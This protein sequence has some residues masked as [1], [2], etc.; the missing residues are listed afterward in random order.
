[1]NQKLSPEK[2]S[3]TRTVST[4]ALRML[5]SQ[6][7]LNPTAFVNTVIQESINSL[8]SD[9]L[10]ETGRENVRVRV[11]ID[12]VLYELGRV[13]LDTFKRISGRIKV[14]SKLDPTERRRIQ[15]GQF[16]TTHEG[17]MIN[18]RVEIAQT[19]YG[20]L[21]VI[22]IHEKKT[23]VVALSKL[24]LSKT[25]YEIYQNML[26][27]RSGLILFCGPTGSGKT[28]TLYSTITKLNEDQN[29]N[30]MTIEDP[31]EFQLEGINQMQTQEETGFT[32]ATGL[33]TILRLSP[34]IIFVG[35]IRDQE[36]AKIAVEL[37]LTGQLVLST[38]HAEDAVGALFRLLDLDIESYLLNSVLVGVVAQRLV[39]R[40]C[41]ACRSLYEPSQD[42]ADLFSK[43]MGSP[44]KHLVVGKG[45]TECQGLAYKGRV[46]IFE[47]LK[48][49]AKIRGLIRR[50]VDESTLRGVLEKEAFVTLFRDGLMKCEQG[51][52]TL[53][54]VLRSS[55]I[56]E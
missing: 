19:I 17:R 37:G 45:C 34:D 3:Q 56:I 2:A 6:T 43:V 28:T 13:D 14:L 31:V 36:T 29:F 39:R 20:E 27:R 22:R 9:I 40:V 15:E 11:R 42:E 10:F 4:S 48:M 54:E 32:F 21:V 23:I 55:L 41:P 24:G 47:I 5:F 16:T 49:D 26:Q 38:V 52:T 50:K 53:Q 18:F 51:I 8:A 35:E 33:K 7:T 46:G 1:M 12:G 30:V 25:G 44:P